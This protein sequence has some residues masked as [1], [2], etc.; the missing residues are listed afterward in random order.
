MPILE[1]ILETDGLEEIDITHLLP[2]MPRKL[3]YSFPMVGVAAHGRVPDCHWTTLNFFNYN[4]RDVYLD[5]RMAT[6]NVLEN[7]GRVQGD[8]KFGDAILFLDRQTGNALHSCVYIADEIVFTKNGNN[9]VTP[10]VLMP[11]EEVRKVYAGANPIELVAFRKN[12]PGE[13]AS[14]THETRSAQSGR[15]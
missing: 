5:T 7:Y 11:L 8:W 13:R 14:K 9:L 1:S 12:P 15:E 6:A 10:W 4:A 3:L 2:A